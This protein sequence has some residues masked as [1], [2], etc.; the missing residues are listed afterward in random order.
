MKRE[1]KRPRRAARHRQETRRAAALADLVAQ[2]RDIHGLL[3]FAEDWFF[4]IIGSSMVITAMHQAW[5][6]MLMPLGWLLVGTR[7]RG[8]ATLV[9][10]QSHGALTRTPWLG[11]LLGTAGAGWWILQ[12]VDRYAQSHGIHHTFLGDHEIDPDT[13]QYV[14][15]KLDSQNPNTFVVVN[16]VQLLLG[17]KGI[18]QLPY[19]LRDRLLPE[20]GKAL[21][22]AQV[23]EAVGFAAAWLGMALLLTV[24][25]WWIEF[26]LCWA[27]PFLT[28]FPAAGWLIETLEHFPLIDLEADHIEMTRNRKGSAVERFFLGIHGESWHRVHHELPGVPFPLLRRAHDILMQDPVYARAEK[29]TGG[30]FTKGPDGQP[31]IL[32]RLPAELRRAK[33]PI[34]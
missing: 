28:V 15:Q 3:A 29:K 14:R 11:Q 13:R 23:R 5:A 7:M 10:E 6:A 1:Y 8:L 21:S 22:P 26:T 4:I 18:A 2:K 17:I 9:H 20:K 34:L 19:L 24:N 25:G 30:I 27:V 16:C 31:S 32:S 12:L 33:G